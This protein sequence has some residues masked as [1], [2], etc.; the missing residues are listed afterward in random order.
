[1]AKVLLPRGAVLLYKITLGSWGAVERTRTGKDVGNR[2][3][4]VEGD[5]TVELEVEKWAA[6][7]PEPPRSTLTGDV[8]SH[9]DFPSRHLGN[10][11]TLLVY[12]PPG[13]A[14]ERRKRYPVLYLHDG[15]N[16]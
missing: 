9:P 14:T 11:R 5:T 12:L 1:R 8:R 6:A 4:E 16:V 2:R 13:Y 7:E 3:L 15:Q 10:R